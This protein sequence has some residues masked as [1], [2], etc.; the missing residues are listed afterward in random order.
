M[1]NAEAEREALAG[2][3]AGEAVKLLNYSQVPRFAAA[4]YTKF[5]CHSRFAHMLDADERGG[6]QLRLLLPLPSES[7]LRYVTSISD[8]VS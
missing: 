6:K 1:G 8:D 2:L 4:A 5:L 7:L 3:A